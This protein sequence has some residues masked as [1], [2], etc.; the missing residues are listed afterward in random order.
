VFRAFDPA[1]R[2]EVALKLVKASDMG[3][4]AMVERFLDEA[5]RLAR[6]RHPNVLVVHGADVHEGRAGIWC[7]LIRG[8]TLEGWLAP[9]GKLGARE[10]A[11]IGMDLCRALAAIHA[12]GLVHRDVKTT[13]VMRE[14]GG[15]IV[16][17]DFGAMA[18]VTRGGDPLPGTEMHGTPLAMAPEQFSG[19]VCGPATDIYG[20]GVLLYRLVTRQMPIEAGSFA[21]LRAKHGERA[22]TPLR[23]RRPDLP[24]EFVRIVERC[25]EA[26]PTRRFATAGALERVLAASVGV[27]NAEVAQDPVGGSGTQ[28]HARRNRR[29][30]LAVIA[31][32]VVAGAGIA[33]YVATHP[34]PSRTPTQGSGSPATPS[35]AA[36][37]TVYRVENGGRQPVIPGSRIAVGDRLVLG[38][39]APESAYVY[40]LNEDEKGESYVLFPIPGLEKTNPLPGGIDHLLP[41][42]L[43]GR[44]VSWVV[45]SAGGAESIFV[46][47]SR[48]ALSDLELDIATL[49]RPAP[50]GP[51]RY[52]LVTDRA[53]ISLRGIGGLGDGPKNENSATE[54]LSDILGKVAGQNLSGSDVWVWQTRLVGS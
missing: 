48:H 28:S 18:E 22:G 39:S 20:L 7:D 5:R 19:H 50:G 14:E 34:K 1:L 47:A 11:V 13:N 40:V 45:S 38:F 49:P 33:W 41:G 43:D 35:L 23:D 26:D 32:L 37:A 24:A 21:E 17:M 51:P 36:T 42:R 52:P 3:G 15:R 53:K 6:V 4:R 2:S 9:Q 54:R 12:A 8:Q 27:V 25:L 10:A 31:A 46:V 30:A 44:S 29:A 16:L